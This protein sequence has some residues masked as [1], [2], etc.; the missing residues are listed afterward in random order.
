MSRKYIRCG[1]GANA[2]LVEIVRTGTAMMPTDNSVAL[3]KGDARRKQ[4]HIAIVTGLLSM[5]ACTQPQ[6]QLPETGQPYG[7]GAEMGVGSPSRPGSSQTPFG[8]G[9]AGGLGAAPGPG[10]NMG[11]G[12]DAKPGVGDPVR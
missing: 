3:C 4:V 6:Q 11:P 8:S 12:P 10:A 5:T 7:M 2:E 9:P 1:P